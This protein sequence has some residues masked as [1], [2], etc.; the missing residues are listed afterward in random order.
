MGRKRRLRKKNIK[1]KWGKA[2]QFHKILEIADNP[3]F[4]RFSVKTG[5]SLLFIFPHLMPN[6][7]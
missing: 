2:S 1:S 6:K 3:L 7:K 4:T 5:D